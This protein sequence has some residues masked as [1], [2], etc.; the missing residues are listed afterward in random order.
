MLE[1]NFEKPDG[2]G[3]SMASY[4]YICT[5]KTLCDKKFTSSQKREEKTRQQKATSF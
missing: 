3:I 1:P 2:L 4:I 5:D